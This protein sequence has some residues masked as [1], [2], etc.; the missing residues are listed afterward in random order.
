MR[1]SM[2]RKGGRN[3]KSIVYG[4]DDRGV[5]GWLCRKPKE[6]VLF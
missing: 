5:G 2:E 4:V 6:T 3:E 1:L